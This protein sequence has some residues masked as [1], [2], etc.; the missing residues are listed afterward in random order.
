[1][2]HDLLQFLPL[3]SNCYIAL[4]SDDQVLIGFLYIDLQRIRKDAKRGHFGFEY[5]LKTLGALLSTRA[6]N[7]ISSSKFYTQIEVESMQEFDPDI[8][9]VRAED[10]QVFDFDFNRSILA[11]CSTI[12]GEYEYKAALQI[13][14]GVKRKYA[15]GVVKSPA[16]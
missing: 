1:M 6:F 14:F 11:H 8:V 10:I 4:R 15:L 16:S 5:V 13:L 3:N 9:V 7:G 12:S 2:K